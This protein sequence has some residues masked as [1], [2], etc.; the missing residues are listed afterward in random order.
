MKVVWRSVCPVVGG[1]CVMTC[2]VMLML[3]WSAD[4]VDTKV[5]GHSNTDYWLMLCI[6]FYFSNSACYLPYVQ[7]LKLARYM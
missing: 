4:N 1:Q 6:N 3:G 2:G 5:N 7:V